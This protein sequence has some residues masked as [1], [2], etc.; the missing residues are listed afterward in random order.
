MRWRSG[1]WPSTCLR[2]PIPTNSNDRFINSLLVYTAWVTPKWVLCIVCGVALCFPAVVW[3]DIWVVD[4]KDREAKVESLQPTAKLTFI[5]AFKC[6]NLQI[7][8]IGQQATST[9][10]G[11][12]YTVGRRVVQNPWN[13]CCYCW[14][15]RIREPII[16]R[17][18]YSP[19]F[20]HQANHLCTLNHVI[21]Q[22][23]K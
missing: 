21:Y 5:E 8:G 12:C 18:K 11:S 7:Y 22:V 6:T 4:C 9:S 19:G 15:C 2:C 13:V 10:H 17:C 16:T 20:N 3:G 23:T 14:H 1:F